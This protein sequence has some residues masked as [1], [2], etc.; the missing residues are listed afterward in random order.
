MS[1]AKKPACL[2]MVAC[3][4][5]LAALLGTSTGCQVTVAG[6]TL[7]SPYYMD[8]DVQYFAPGPEFKLQREA[9][10]LKAYKEEQVLQGLQP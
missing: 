3:G 8:D 7:P 6:Q 9:A 4:L 1:A 2:T 10:A 5:G